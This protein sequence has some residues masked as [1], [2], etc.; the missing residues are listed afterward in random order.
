MVGLL[1]DFTLQ[2]VTFRNVDTF[3]YALHH[4]LYVQ[5]IGKLCTK[6]QFPFKDLGEFFAIENFVIVKLS[7]KSAPLESL[8]DVGFH[9]LLYF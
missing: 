3:N 4:F 8:L 5:F 7:Q 6:E 1:A 9:R 2:N